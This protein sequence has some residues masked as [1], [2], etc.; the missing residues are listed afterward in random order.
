MQNIELINFTKLSHE[1][2]L[3]ILE[4]RNDERVAKFMQNKSMSLAEHLN[5]IESL[6]NAKNK[7]YFLLKDSEK[8]IGMIDFVDICSDICEFGVYAN[9]SIKAQGK[10]LLHT[11]LGY[12]FLG[13]NV[14]QIN[15]Y[16]FNEN[17]RAIRLY[18]DFGFEMVKKDEKY[19]F[20]QIK[21]EG[22][23][24]QIVMKNYQLLSDDENR[25]I[26]AIRNLE[27]VRNMSLNDKIISLKEHKKWLQ[28]S[29]G[30][31]T[32][33]A[34]LE[35]GKICGGINLVLS[36]GEY[37]WGL[38]FKSNTSEFVVCVCL[39]FWNLLLQRAKR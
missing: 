25:K 6:K 28:D 38:F 27:N 31:N 26:L 1:Q 15:A 13:L 7:R 20:F 22:E 32:Y 24:M 19:S 16:A 18:A 36:G 29:Q 30:G 2:K 11:I 10:T 12:G 9:P 21:N 34:V 5:F 39:A 37:S 4:W 17:E 3:M 23:M 33:L 8:F 14:S 35:D